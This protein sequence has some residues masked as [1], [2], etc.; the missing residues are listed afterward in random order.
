[1]TLHRLNY[2]RVAPEPYRLLAKLN[3]YLGKSALGPVLLQLIFLRVSQINGCSYC[4]VTHARE[5]RSLGVANDRIDGVASWREAPFYDA[6]ER[7]AL[8]WAEALT[9]VAETHAPDG[10]Y[11]CLRHS[12]TDR[13]MVD[14]TFAIS[15]IN[16]WNRIAI[17]FRQSPDLAPTAVTGPEKKG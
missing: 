1:M 3:E 15:L 9:A 2:L 6:R 7:A 16:A 12:F 10:D 8:N 11:D 17:G 4:V 13:E 5:L 14:L